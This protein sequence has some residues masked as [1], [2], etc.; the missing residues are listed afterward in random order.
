MWCI[1]LKRYR[2]TLSAITQIGV[3]LDI[4]A[5][6][7]RYR[8]DRVFIMRRI[9]AHFA[10]QTLLFWTLHHWIRIHVHRSFN[11]SSVST[12]HIQWYCWQVNLW[13]IHIETS[14][15]ILVSLS[16]W[17]LTATLQNPDGTIYSWR[18]SEIMKRNTTYQVLAGWMRILRKDQSDNWVIDG[19]ALCTRK[20]LPRNYG[21]ME[22]Y[23]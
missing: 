15:I 11:T 4:L 22:W 2:A 12:Q 6:A 19:T 23:G 18:L 3:R 14:V 9:N 10:K 8:D 21:I 17:R 20:K 1:G 7:R 13:G 5:L 16:T